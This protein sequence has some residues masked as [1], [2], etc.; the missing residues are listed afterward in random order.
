MIFL[1]L[2]LGIAAG[3]LAERG[4]DW[5]LRSRQAE[6]ALLLTPHQQ[7]WLQAASAAIGALF[8][9]LTIWQYGATLKAAAVLGAY[10]Y[11][12]LLALID[13]KYHIVP[14]RLV[15]P[16]I[17]GILLFYTGFSL[18]PLAITFVGGLLAFSV[19]AL[20]A[21]LKPN[22]LGGGDIKLASLIGFGF[23]FPG[24]LW[25][26]L[27]GTSV[28]GVSML[29]LRISSGKQ[30]K[31]YLPYAPFLCLGAIIALLYNPTQ[32]LLSAYL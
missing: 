3:Y 14:N 2:L 29:I 9:A 13:L 24:T 8:F 11:L 22:D 28:G 23:G 12:Y 21:F 1:S 25:A 10:C 32:L 17:V 18:R 20:T 26:L 16:A 4:S 15:Y 30:G 27:L 19:F 6:K 5:L 31:R 7:I